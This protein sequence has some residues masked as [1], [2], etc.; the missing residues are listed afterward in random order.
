MPHDLPPW[1]FNV[2]FPV[3]RWIHLVASTLIVGGVLFF[4]FI[5]PVATADL[6]AEQQLAVFGRARWVFRKVVWMSVI[7]LL[8][9]GGVSMWRMWWSYR[10]DQER[11]GGF[12]FASGPW[13]VGH[14]VLAMVGVLIA[15]RVTSTRRLHSRPVGWMQALLVILLVCIFAASVARHVRLHMREWREGSSGFG[16]MADDN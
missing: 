14:V 6:K 11:A 15:F 3:N 4:E 5:V 13:V 7:A 12:W 16:A 10:G 8:F 1:L 9:S 2:I